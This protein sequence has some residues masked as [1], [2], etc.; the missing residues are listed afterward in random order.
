[1]GFFDGFKKKEVEL[2]PPPLPPI[3]NTIN[4]INNNSNTNISQIGNQDN[5]NLNN[6]D[7][8]LLKD[9]LNLNISL[10]KNNINQNS[11]NGS[12]N[13]S[14]TNI[15]IEQ[16][17]LNLDG[18]NT[19]IDKDKINLNDNN[20]EIRDNIKRNNEIIEDKKTIESI[21]LNENNQSNSIKNN[22]NKELSIPEKLP[23]LP[24]KIF[25]MPEKKLPE[26]KINNLEN[27]STDNYKDDLAVFK[28]F[29]D[30]D[31]KIEFEIP[32]FSDANEE[33]ILKNINSKIDLNVFDFEEPDSNIMYNIGNT[34]KFDKKPLFI[35]TDHYSSILATID[36]VKEYTT[37]SPTIIYNLENLKKNQ[38]IEHK[39][40]KNCIEDIQRKIIYV[41][42]V[43]FEKEVF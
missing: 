6:L 5:K 42:K 19:N 25:N 27:N 29:S 39:K 14:N 1:M 40:L 10:N 13:N 4:N 37:N 15:N 2:P 20:L 7:I 38:D 36:S 41:D 24:E 18:I 43:L 26:L 21:V 11:S 9:N 34:K 3:T 32:V 35:R 33:E 28:N 22:E 8:G 23:G 12:I 16:K 30:S 17:N 31:A